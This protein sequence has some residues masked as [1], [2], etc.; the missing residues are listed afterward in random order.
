ME[1]DVSHLKKGGTQLSET[2]GDETGVVVATAKTTALQALLEFVPGVY[3]FIFHVGASEVV[4]VRKQ[5]FVPGGFPFGDEC[6]V[7]ELVA[8]SQVFIGYTNGKSW[9]ELLNQF[10]QNLIAARDHNTLPAHIRSGIGDHLDELLKLT[11]KA[12]QKLNS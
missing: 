1:S 2:Q 11:Q 5:G 12:L 7:L 6:G 4:D 3:P 8:A 10:T 9:F